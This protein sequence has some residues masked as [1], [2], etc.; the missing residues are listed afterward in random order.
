MKYACP[1]CGLKYDSDTSTLETH[2]QCK[3]CKKYFVIIPQTIPAP[4]QIFL[5]IETT[6]F[7]PSSGEITTI[8]WYGDGVWNYWAN[9]GMDRSSLEIA[10][11]HSHELISFNGKNFDEPWL[12]DVFNFSPHDN[13]LDLYR[14]CTLPP[15]SGGLKEIAKYL[16]ISRPE[17]LDEIH[18]K[19]AAKLWKSAVKGN[20]CSLCN[21]LYYNAWDVVLTYKL[22]CHLYGIPPHNIENNIPFAKNHN[23][24]GVFVKNAP[25]RKTGVQNNPLLTKKLWQ[26]R[27]NN[28]MS[29]L[30]GAHL[31]FTGD[32][33]RC[34]REEAVALVAQLGGIVR[35]S[36]VQRLDFLIVGDTGKYGITHKIK[37][38]QE[39]IER[40]AHV[41]IISENEFW[42]FVEN[43]EKG[44]LT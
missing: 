15:V 32:L 25:Y 9:N 1:H 43:T 23:A 12:L 8:V 3:N 33:E 19:H 38:A 6:A 7:R 30:K 4:Q 42:Q 40:G 10:W 2:I 26:K 39:Y 27:R 13:H 44:E 20:K 28:P 37:K 29:N 41:Q 24:L 36:V 31:C 34:E 22:Y 16:N 35:K 17:I 18:G 11:N 5:D 21:L 14:D